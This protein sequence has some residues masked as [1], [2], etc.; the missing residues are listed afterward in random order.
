MRVAGRFCLCVRLKIRCLE[1][2]RPASHRWAGG[3]GNPSK[4]FRAY[5]SCSCYFSSKN[6]HSTPYSSPLSLPLSLSL[7]LNTCFQAKLRY[8]LTSKVITDCTAPYGYFYS[9]V[10]GCLGLLLQKATDEVIPRYGANSQASRREE[11]LLSMAAYCI[12]I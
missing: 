12:I 9:S 8:E 4:A 10:G 6:L 1:W 11:Y 3:G 7:C 2:G 5:S